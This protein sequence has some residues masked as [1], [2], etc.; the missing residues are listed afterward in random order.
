MPCFADFQLCDKGKIEAEYWI[1]D[2]TNLGL[3]ESQSCAT[4][5]VL[6][7]IICFAR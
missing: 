1:R 7:L 3:G 6:A 2:I 5:A 4:L